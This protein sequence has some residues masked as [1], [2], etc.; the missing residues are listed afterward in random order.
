MGDFTAALDVKIEDIEKPPLV[1]T[2]HYTFS[3]TK[4]S[5]GEVGQGKWD[6]VDFALKGV[7]AGE[8]VDPELLA[9]AGGV[10]QVFS[11]KRF[12]LNKGSEAEDEAQFNRT[13]DNIRTFLEKHLGVDIKG[14]SLKEGIDSAVGLQCIGEIKHRVRE[15]TGDP[16]ADLGRTAPVE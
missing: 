11:F 7:E 15:D 13:L 2:G 12:M 5:F 8:D 6:T 10:E 14:L 4:V 1:P 9:E 16:I 3:V